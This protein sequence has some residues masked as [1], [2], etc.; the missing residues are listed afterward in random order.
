MAVLQTETFCIAVDELDNSMLSANTAC[1]NS[2]QTPVSNLN[3]TYTGWVP[4]LDASSKLIAMVRNGA[5]G[6]A[7]SYTLT[8]QNINTAPVRSSNVTYYLDRNYL[9]NSTATNVQV[10]F[11]FLTSE[12]NGLMAADPTVTFSNIGASRQGGTTCTA[13]F[14]PLNGWTTFLSQNSNGISTDGLVRWIE[15]TTPSFSNF[16]LKGALGGPLPT[17]LVAFSGQKE[18]SVNKLRW[19]TATESNNLGFEVQ[20]STDG[21][22]YTVISFVNTLA[23][24]GNSN[25]I[26]N[27]NYA[28]NNPPGSKQYYRLRQIDVDNHSKFSNIIL[29]KDNKAL[30]LAIAGLF[31]NPATGLINI[32]LE[33]PL[34]ENVTLLIMD[35]A[36]QNSNSENYEY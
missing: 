5:G 24:G 29:I 25:D 21:I 31:P 34:H 26:L 7:S 10:K 11:F 23:M 3:N 9:I 22:N 13:D 32:M 27:Y 14:S 4:L 33:A 6:D 20:R 8:S 35:A 12:L 36:G 18:G 2:F 1:A 28:D 16:F 17:N 15:V 19:I 30:T